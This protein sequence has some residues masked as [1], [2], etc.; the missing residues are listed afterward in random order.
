MAKGQSGKSYG[1]CSRRRSSQSSPH[2]ANHGTKHRLRER[3]ASS[4]GSSGDGSSS[5]RSKQSTTH[6]LTSTSPTRGTWNT[7]GHHDERKRRGPFLPRIYFIRK[8]YEDPNTKKG[9]V[10]VAN[11]VISIPKAYINLFTLAEWNLV[12]ERLTVYLERD[13]ALKPVSQRSF[14]I[15]LSSKER[16]Y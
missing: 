11:E 1:F 4:V 12:K 8:V 9:F 16:V 6:L 15:N 5:A 13:Q 3:T 7:I 2:R 10:D 14:K